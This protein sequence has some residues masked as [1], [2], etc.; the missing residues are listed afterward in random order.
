MPII[1]IGN[2]P[3]DQYWDQLYGLRQINADNAFTLWDFENG[4]IQGLTLIKR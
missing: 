4:E 3:N 1:K 2:E